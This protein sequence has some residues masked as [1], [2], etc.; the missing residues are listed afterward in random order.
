VEAVLAQKVRKNVRNMTARQKS[1]GLEA[2]LHAGGM[3]DGDPEKY[4]WQQQP[5]PKPKLPLKQQ[6][7][8]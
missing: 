1:G 4:Q 3:Q 5:K 2:Q 8:W 7:K 6:P